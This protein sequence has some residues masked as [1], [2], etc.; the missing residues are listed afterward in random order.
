ML[1]SIVLIPVDCLDSLKQVQVGAY[2]VS[3]WDKVLVA[4][5]DYAREV[6]LAGVIAFHYISR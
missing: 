3:I 6:A 1:R 5:A 4:L 2:R